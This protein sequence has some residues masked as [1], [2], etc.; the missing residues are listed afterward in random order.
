VAEFPLEESVRVER[1]FGFLDA[2][3]ADERQVAED[4]NL[5]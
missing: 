1:A 2:G 3:L 5:F 4:A